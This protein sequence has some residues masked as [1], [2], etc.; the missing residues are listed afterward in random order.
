ML[1]QVRGLG[2]LV[3]ADKYSFNFIAKVTL[4]QEAA[5]LVQINQI[6][7]VA[8]RKGVGVASAAVLSEVE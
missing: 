4:P 8:T 6:A 2:T 5:R 7:S 3:H 1:R